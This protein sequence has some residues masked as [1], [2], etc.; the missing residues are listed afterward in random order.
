MTWVAGVTGGGLWLSPLCPVL[1]S[2]WECGGVT[3]VG[4]CGA[5]R[6]E[7]CVHGAGPQAFR[8]PS[9]IRPHDPMSDDVV[10]F[11]KC[12]ASNL[13]DLFPIRCKLISS[14]LRTE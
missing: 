1:S 2:L 3:A 12:H 8:S 14:L 10:I 7:R 6:G 11:S 13:G 9:A 5:G 4:H